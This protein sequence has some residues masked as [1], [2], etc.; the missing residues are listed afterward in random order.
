MKKKLQNLK[1]K[2]KLF[3][4]FSLFVTFLMIISGVGL[5]NVSSINNSVKSL[6]EEHLPSVDLLL[7]I[8]RDM[9]QAVVAQRTM[10]FSNVGTQTFD[11]LKKDNE[12]NIKQAV[13]RWEQYKMLGHDGVSDELIT[14]YEKAREEWIKYSNRIVGAREADTPEGRIEAIEL[15]FRE[16]SKSFETAREIINNLTEI[17]EKV[18]SEE[19]ASSQSNYH[20]SIWVMSTGTLVILVLS[21]LAGMIISKMIRWI[22]LQTYFRDSPKQCMKLPTVTWMLKFNCSIPKTRLLPH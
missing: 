7:Q 19:V 16:G 8:D 2:Q 11:N 13:D 12:E 22:P 1:V 9:Q 15:S 5:F 4:T 14:N 21:I 20:T 10:I 6:G 3:I 18:S 17:T